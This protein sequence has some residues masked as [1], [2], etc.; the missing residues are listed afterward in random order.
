MGYISSRYRKVT[1]CHN[2]FI[3]NSRMVHNQRRLWRCVFD[4]IKEKPKREIIPVKLKSNGNLHLFRYMQAS[5]FIRDAASCRL[6][7]VSPVLWN[8]PFEKLFFRES[9]QIGKIEYSVRCI[10]MTYDWI[11][12]EEAAWLRSG[13]DSEVVRV[14]Y[15]FDK[16]CAELNGMMD[17]DFYFS[18]VDYSLPRQDI[19][20]LSNDYKGG[21]WAPNSIDDYLNVISLKRKAFMYEN[22]IRLFMVKKQPINGDIISLGYFNSPIVSVCL[23][24]KRL[25][26]LDEVE[27]AKKRYGIDVKQSRL[28]DIKK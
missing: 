13:E 18:I 6:T 25:S 21:K 24:P 27:K 19:I 17:Y 16:L 4:Y 28:Y 8:D 22:E 1:G 5:H 9:I 10:C 15:D 20:T 3:N 12:S 11:E 26:P 14:E 23:P 2:V 7:F